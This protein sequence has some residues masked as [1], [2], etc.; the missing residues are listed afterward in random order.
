MYDVFSYHRTVAGLQA[1]LSLTRD[2]ESA[3]YP[4][5]DGLLSHTTDVRSSVVL[6]NALSDQDAK[7]NLAV[8]MGELGA[9]LVE[10]IHGLDAFIRTYE[11]VSGL[12]LG[13]YAIILPSRAASVLTTPHI[14]DALVDDIFYIVSLL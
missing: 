9:A 2:C 1:Q 10:Q 14:A 12:R 5:D 11:R 6:T 3:E 4:E 8:L 7:T 13:M